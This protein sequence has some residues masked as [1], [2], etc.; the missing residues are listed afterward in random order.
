[1]SILQLPWLEGAVAVALL[2]ALT[3]SQVRAPL[4]AAR[5]ALAFTG[6]AFAC[7]VLAWLSFYLGTPRQE[8]WSVQL[9]LLGRRLLDLDNLNAPLVPV[10][11]LLHFLTAVATTRTKMRRY[12][13]S[14]SLAD[15][16]IRLCAFS[17]KAP[18]ALIGLL[19]ADIIPGYVELVNRR[20]PTR[21]YLLHMALFATLLI[22]GWALID[23][24]GGTTEGDA[25]AWASVA[26]L[27]AVLIRCGVV[28][29]HCWLT[30]WFEHAS[31]GNAILFVTPLTGV[32]AAVRLVLP[33]APEWA[34]QGIG[35]ISLA[36]AVY[37]AGMATVQREARRFY[38]YLFLS[39]ASLVLVGLE[40]VTVTPISLTGA[41]SLWF[42]VA[43]SLTGFGLTLRALEARFGRLP[44]AE[45]HGLYEHAPALAVCFL[46]TGLASVG[47]PGTLGFVAADLL[48][49]GAAEANLYLGVAVVAAAALN[50][51]AVLR[52]Y[53]LLFTGARH[54]STVSLGIVPR[55]RL[56]VLTLSVLIF[57]G[58][59]FPEPGI[60]SRHQAAEE[61][62]RERRTWQGTARG[63]RPEESEPPESR[64]QPA[65]T[66]A[67]AANTR[68]S[69]LRNRDAGP[70]RQAA[71][72]ISSTDHT[73]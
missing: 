14:W 46:V 65:T 22:V 24:P 58:G 34:L 19:I 26:L 41:L 10:V 7:A 11:A 45:F 60:V 17:C 32:Y 33:V 71:P 66:R 5:L 35:V 25:N 3:V 16:A 20:R 27:L 8:I 40:L 61:I 57:G 42:S 13:F 39:H 18:W 48:V 29:V 37:S 44:L 68:Q 56:A 50:S 38:A 4:R 2:G 51:I 21:V 23:V 36:T 31:F 30:D 53:L 9:W 49:D 28:P 70:P 1:M 73:D 43:L 54:V 69:T 47:F 72:P 67:P 64:P 59:L 62:L 12:S 6:S 15:E 52:A 63:R 55:E